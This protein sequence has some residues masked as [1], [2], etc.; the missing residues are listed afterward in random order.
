VKVETDEGI[1]GAAIGRRGHRVADIVKRRLKHLVGMDPMLTESLWQAVWEIDRIEELQVHDL[2]LLDLACWDIK[3]QKAQLPVYQ[4]LGGHQAT[5]PA[6]ASTV[7]WDTMEEYERH[8]KLCLEEGFTAFKLHAWGDA[9][10]DA[11]LAH[12]LRKWTGP[13]TD[14]MFDGS[15][16]WD[17]VTALSFG[18]VLEDAGFL[19][20][21]EPMREFDLA[22]YARLCEA[23]DIPVLAAETSDGAHWN[24]AT[25]IHCR[26][27]DMVRTSTGFKG[28]FT[29]AIKVAHLAESFGMR[30]EVHGGGH[31]NLQLCAAI[32]NNTFYEALVIDEAQIRSL[33]DCGD[34]SIVAG[35]ITA[36]STPGLQP[37]P[38]WAYIEGEAIAVI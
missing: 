38:D 5:V 9:K 7:T 29:G 1:V 16:G 37:T 35:S 20:Y 22:S 8:I 30:A 18:R 31:A 19:W 27:L 3:S 33:K 14:L 34:L 4:M 26:A 36:P 28:G 32:P 23:L 6:Y 11:K 13:D 15:A 21:E 12:N 24:A 2:G 25:W 10:E 17:Y